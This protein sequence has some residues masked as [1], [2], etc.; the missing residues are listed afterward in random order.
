L[1]K[2]GARDVILLGRSGAVTDAAKAGVAALEA[3]GANV[4]VVKAD[5]ADMTQL[6]DA[7]NKALHDL[8]PLKGVVHSAAVLRDSMIANITR[9]QVEMSLQAKAIGAWN[10][11]EY[12]KDL[13]LDFFTMY[14]SATTVLG[15]PGQV[16]YVAANMVLEALAQHR[17]ANGLPAVTYGWGPISDTGMLTKAP[18]V[19]ESLK[20]VMGVA[21][22]SSSQALDYME[23]SPDDQYTNLFYFNLDWH[24]VR[25]LTF[26]NTTMFNWIDELKGGGPTRSLNADSAKSILALEREE[27]IPALVESIGVEVAAML[28][29]PFESMDTSL[30]IAELGLD[31]LMAVELGLLIEERFGVKVSSFSMNVS[32]DLTALSERIYEA[33][34]TG[35]KDGADEAEEVAKIMR[36]KHGINASSESVAKTL[37]AVNSE[38]EKS[39]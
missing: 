23:F 5:V 39:E 37:D 19:M 15:N 16:N 4:V 2:N 34:L 21:E 29:V 20:R 9:E 31:S 14:S 13:D 36:D 27:A 30:S 8:P 33:L 11:H 22:L 10:I 25:D 26:I 1:V 18:E 7:L 17:R 12:T 32:S 35:D 6:D 28:K 3:S 38:L 24:R